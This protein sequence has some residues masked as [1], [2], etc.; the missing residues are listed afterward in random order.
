MNLII[1]QIR[2]ELKAIA[3]EKTRITILTFFKEPIKAYGI[4][5]AD[6][7]KISKKHYNS[8]KTKTKA[9]IFELCE[10]LWQ[11]GYI[12]ESTIA[13]HWSYNVRKNYEP[14]DFKLFEQWVSKYISNWAACDGFCNHTIGEIVEKYPEYLTELKKWATSE[15]KWVRRASAVSLIAPAKRGRFLNDIFEIADILLLDKEDMVQK[16]Y[17][18]MLKV[19][20]NPYQ[21][22]VFD[23]V[24]KN[25][26]T[27]PR[28][29][30][31]YA[32]EKM[33]PE[34]KSKAM[35]K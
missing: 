31:R 25:K 7:N 2:Q 34:L 9:E 1:N 16:G 19:A 6:V 33:P 20:S 24:M 15:N 14:A 4:I 27:M 5:N 11:S 26:A 12:E 30:L 23:Y 10:Q 32:I 22:E 28:T 21:K 35:E 18:W 17:G 8:V 13:C 3:N 29:A